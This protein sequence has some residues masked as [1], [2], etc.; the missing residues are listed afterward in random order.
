MPRPR[1]W[2][3]DELRAAV[4]ASSTMA[5]VH[6]RV[7][8]R[9]GRYD[10]MLRHMRRI[11]VEHDHLMVTVAGRS[12]PRRSKEWTDDEF[13]AVVAASS[14][15]S[16]VARALGYRPNGGMHRWVAAR[17]RALDLDTSHF[18]RY[19]WTKNAVF[20]GCRSTPLA[21]I[22]VEGSRYGS[23]ALRKRLIAAGLKD[24]RCESCGLV[25]WRGVPVPLQLDHINGDHTDNRL[26]NL[27]ILCPN[28]HALTDTW[29]ARGRKS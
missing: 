29:C 20:T 4:V 7:G 5:E 16:D 26:A 3:D 1:S 24:G 2:T 19:A 21:E 25:E 15:V 6:R 23:G 10:A 13:R 9:P 22:L 28:C 14:T 17:I 18:D 11:G 27:R 8:L 12:R